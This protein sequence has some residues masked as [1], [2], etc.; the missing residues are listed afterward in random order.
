[1]HRQRSLRPRA[2]SAPS[3]SIK[4]N[5]VLRWFAQRPPQPR[6]RHSG[7]WERPRDSISIPGDEPA[8]PGF[9]K[10]TPRKVQCHVIRPS[11]P[12][13]AWTRNT[14]Q[15]RDPP[16]AHADR[17]L[18]AR[19]ST[20]RPM[21]AGGSE[22][23]RYGDALNTYPSVRVPPIGQGTRMFPRTCVRPS[24]WGRK[25]G[26]NINQSRTSELFHSSRCGSVAGSSGTVNKSLRGASVRHHHFS[27]GSTGRGP[28]PDPSAI[29]Q[30]P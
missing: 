29:G 14:R 18:K 19:R 3:V 12:A 17:L 2:R 11:S 24:R 1:M 7:R 15:V 21:R 4:M 25:G 9:V 16:A 28:P 30:P 8:P 23:S 10:A 27:P 5:K 13:Q 6:L 20:H 26:G 22:N